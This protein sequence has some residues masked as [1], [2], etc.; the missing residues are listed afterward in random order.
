MTGDGPAAVREATAFDAPVIAALSA[1]GST[2]PWS[3]EAVARIL[4]LPGCWAL[5]AGNATP[6]GFVIARVA[7]DEGEIVNLVVAERDRGKGIG[8]SLVAAA[9]EHAAG[10]GAVTMYLEVAED[11][12]AARA[13]YEAAGFAPVGKRPEYYRQADGSNVDAIIMRRLI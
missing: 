10:R 2:E 9:L 11:N 7:A 12:A 6:T 3:A 5:V 1:A 13:L 8:R 4:T